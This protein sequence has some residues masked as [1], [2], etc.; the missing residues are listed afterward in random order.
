MLWPMLYRGRGKSNIFLGGKCLIFFGVG[1]CYDPWVIVF[2]FPSVMCLH[3]GV[4]I[5]SV[6]LPHLLVY[7]WLIVCRQCPLIGLIARTADG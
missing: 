4:Y 3:F 5:L 6:S 7:E 2:W 1:R